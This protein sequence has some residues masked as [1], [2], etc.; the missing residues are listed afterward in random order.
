[1][2]RDNIMYLYDST[3]DGLMNCIFEAF[4]QKETPVDISYD[5]HTLLPYRQILTDTDKAHCVKYSIKTK[6]GKDIYR[7]VYLAYLS[8][9][10]GCEL[11]ILEFVRFCFSHKGNASENMNTPIVLKMFCLA[12]SVSRE[13]HHIMEFLRFN[14]YNGNLIAVINPEYFVLPLIASHFENRFYNENFLIFDENHFAALVH[15]GKR[16]EIIPVDE[17]IVPEFT[18]EEKK[19]QTLWKLFY[20]T[21]EIKQRRN[22]NLRR[23]HLPKRFWKNVTELKDEYI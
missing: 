17:F 9:E 15:I 10:K 23:T 11:D 3:F 12:K 22:Y 21:I 5:T 13:Q 1:M 4:E 19:F 18:E 7:I 14:D 16:T 8:R 20:D 6:L 2:A